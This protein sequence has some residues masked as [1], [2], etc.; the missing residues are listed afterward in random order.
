MTSQC[1]DSGIVRMWRKPAR[2]RA[3]NTRLE[4]RQWRPRLAAMMGWAG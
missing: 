4:W 1:G 3:E 2:G